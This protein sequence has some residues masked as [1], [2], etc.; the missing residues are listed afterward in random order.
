[1]AATEHLDIKEHFQKQFTLFERSLNGE[2]S[3][4]MH[5]IR[6]KALE[7]FSQLPFPTRHD[8]DWRFTNIAPMLQI[9]FSAVHKATKTN[10]PQKQLS[11]LILPEREAFNLVFV[12][13]LFAPSLSTVDIDPVVTITPISALTDAQ[14]EFLS[15]KLLDSS[16]LRQDIFSTLNSAF[17]RDGVFISIPENFRMEKP[18]H[19]LFLTASNESIITHPRV[20][21]FAGKNSHSTI[22]ESYHSLHEARYF[23]NCVTEISLGE[24]ATLHHTKVQ[25]ESEQAFH[26]S[27]MQ[28]VQGRDSNFTSNVISF[29]GAL[30][31]NNIATTLQGEGAWCSLNGLYMA[32]GKQHV[33]NHTTID[34]A[35]PHAESHE[36]YKGI[37]DQEARG[38]F[39]GRI[40][41]RPDAQKTDA[42]QQNKN[43]LLSDTA[44][45]DTKP[46]LEIYANDV[47]CTHGATVGQLDED[48]LFYLR[49]RGIDRDAAEDILT[50]AFA[51][52]VINRISFEPMRTRLEEMIHAKL[53]KN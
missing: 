32:H 52:D 17:I 41:V 37:L 18:I 31:R 40:I 50:H 48:Q 38:V 14:Q 12:D 26:I 7:Q 29:G 34:H 36:L 46:Q 43:L 49:A 44:T 51:R 10:I 25:N 24:N 28:S 23:T 22:F 3:S 19:M 35:S 2:A 45:I 6:K 27:S 8:E 30:V 9:P 5:T 33:D 1:M 11:P 20:I 47:K 42:K 16:A 4:P 39:H 21:I 53:G 13:G 15:S